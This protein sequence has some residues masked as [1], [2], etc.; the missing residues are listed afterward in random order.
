MYFIIFGKC[1]VI[2]SSNS[3][4]LSF[5]S[6]L[7]GTLITIIFYHLAFSNRSLRLYS[8]FFIFP[9]H[10]CVW[11]RIGIQEILEKW[12]SLQMGNRMCTSEMN[13]Y[14][15]VVTR[16]KIHS[17]MWSRWVFPMYLLNE[18]PDVPERIFIVVDKNKKHA[19]NSML[20]S[21]IK[22]SVWAIVQCC[23]RV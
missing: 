18:C 11:T 12:F 2:T 20:S 23:V 6:P 17:H 8:F 13:R 22:Y 7:S 21:F 14:I 9:L 4:C 15:C 19:T 3:S 10:L 5:F 1:L 16:K